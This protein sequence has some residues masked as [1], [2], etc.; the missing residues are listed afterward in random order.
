MANA[1]YDSSRL[2]VK[3]PMMRPGESVAY[4]TLENGTLFPV[5]VELQGRYKSG[6]L[7]Y[8]TVGVHDG[9][10][11]MFDMKLEA[12][13][14]LGFA[15]TASMFRELPVAQI[16]EDVKGRMG[17]SN[18]AIVRVG[19]L[20]AA[21][22]PHTWDRGVLTA[23]EASAARR[24]AIGSRR[25]RPVSPEILSRVAAI[26]A[27]NDYDPRQQVRAELN[28]SERTASRYIAAVKSQGLPEEEK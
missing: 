21:G 3:G 17:T 19:E 16:I 12:D 11:V 7:L 5:R 23:E 13:E 1:K 10:A 6:P 28:V 4:T 27:S 8:W 9:Q 15:L 14:S 25:G 18:A 20:E 22:T 24:G 2:N 26:V